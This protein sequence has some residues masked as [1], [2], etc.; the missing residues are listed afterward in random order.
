MG[1]GPISSHR[2]ATKVGRSCGIALEIKVGSGTETE[3][4]ISIDLTLGAAENRSGKYIRRGG[5]REMVRV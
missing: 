3:L 5:R 1:K 4:L 2:A